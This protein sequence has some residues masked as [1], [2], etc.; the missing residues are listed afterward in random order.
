MAEAVGGIVILVVIV[1]IIVLASSIKIV[2]E[3]ERAVIFRLG[4]SVGAKGP[5]VFFIVPILDR[6][7]RVNLQIV[8]VPVASQAVITKD[9]IGDVIKAGALTKAQICKGIAAACAKVGLS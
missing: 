5:G 2:Q 3:Y 7:V 4:R 6:I 8:A 1:A 9:N